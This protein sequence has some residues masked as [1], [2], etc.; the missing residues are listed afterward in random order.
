[1]TRMSSVRKRPRRSKKRVVDWATSRKD[2][3]SGGLVVISD[4]L[5]KWAG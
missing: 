2:R 3:G 4:E 1:M 5:V